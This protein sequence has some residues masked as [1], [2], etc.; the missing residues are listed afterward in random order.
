MFYRQEGKGRR[1]VHQK[2]QKK[3]SPHTGFSVGKK[4][5]RKH[6]G[7]VFLTEVAIKLYQKCTFGGRREILMWKKKQKEKPGSLMM[8]R[9]GDRG[10]H[11]EKGSAP[12]TQWGT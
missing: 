4:G 2:G 1:G 8:G 10:G 6:G 5:R 11:R 7:A 12:L 3:G 9:R